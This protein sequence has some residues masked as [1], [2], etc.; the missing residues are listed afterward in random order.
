MPA[1]PKAQAFA[2]SPPQR[3]AETDE[4]RFSENQ[5]NGFGKPPANRQTCRWAEIY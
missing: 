3:I 5:K 4:I 1:A 2:R